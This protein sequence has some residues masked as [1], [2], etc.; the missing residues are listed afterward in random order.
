[1]W[2]AAAEQLCICASDPRL[3]VGRCR[4]KHVESV[5]FSRLKL[6]CDEPLSDISVNFNL[7][8]YVEES[9]AAPS[10]LAALARLAAAGCQA[11]GDDTHVGCA[12][13]KVGRCNL[14]ASI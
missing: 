1:M 8:R 12:A 2:C 9:L 14:K 6:K 10:T 11:A 7:R 5:C 3:E 4:L 13:L